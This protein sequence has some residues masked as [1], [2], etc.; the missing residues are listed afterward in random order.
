MFFIL[1]TKI[2]LFVCLQHLTRLHTS[3]SLRLVV[4]RYSCKM[5]ENNDFLISN[6]QMLSW[7]MLSIV[8]VVSSAAITHKLCQSFLT[9]TNPKILCFTK[10][11]KFQKK[12]IKLN[13]ILNKNLIFVM[14]IIAL[15]YKVSLYSKVVLRSL[16][17]VSRIQI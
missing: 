16:T 3:C 5:T 15:K 7:K 2:K 11:L 14:K 10:V 1:K 8:C 13:Q 6:R 17:K 4:W 9:K 12:K